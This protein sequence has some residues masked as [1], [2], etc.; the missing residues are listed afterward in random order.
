V[1][2]ALLLTRFLETLLFGV[3]T[4]DPLTFVA[5]ALLLAAVAGV[6]CLVPARRA[7]RVQP[8]VA[9]RAE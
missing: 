3:G 5:I 1:V 8:M 9:L 6:A 4:R 7:A 2:G